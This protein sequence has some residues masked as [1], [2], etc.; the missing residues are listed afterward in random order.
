MTRDATRLDRKTLDLWDRDVCEL[1]LAPDARRP[2][3]YFEFEAAPTGEWLDFELR[4]LPDRRETNQDYRSGMT[5]SARVAA[6]SF[7]LALRVP[8]AG[9]PSAPRAGDR[10]RA[11]L[12]RCVGAGPSRGYLAWRPTETPR[13]NFHVPHKF[14]RLLF[15]A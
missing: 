5:T 6:D 11:N 4:Q 9:L 3:H 14:G 13:P 10:W 1:F 2:E 12:Y 8:W 7:T 15:E